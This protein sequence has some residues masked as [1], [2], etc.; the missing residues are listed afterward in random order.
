[1]MLSNPVA[2]FFAKAV[3]HAKQ[4]RMSEFNQLEAELIM[5]GE[6]I[7]ALKNHRVYVDKLVRYENQ[8]NEMKMII[9]NKKKEL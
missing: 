2:D 3:V 4:N 7:L 6:Q 8:I 5:L 1:M 9:R